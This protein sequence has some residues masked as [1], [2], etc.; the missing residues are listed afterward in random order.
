MTDSDEAVVPPIPTLL[1][2]ATP[3][4]VLYV[5]WTLWMVN[6][7]V[8][9]TIGGVAGGI[10]GGGL[11]LEFGIPVSLA[12][13]VWFAVRYHRDHHISTVWRTRLAGRPVAAFFGRRH[14]FGLQRRIRYSP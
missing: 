11:R 8:F 6:L 4:H 10:F 12:L 7:G 14:R 5:P 2:V 9:L 13:Q 3:P 1:A